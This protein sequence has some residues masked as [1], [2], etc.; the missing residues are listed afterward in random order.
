M[1]YTKLVLPILMCFSTH[2]TFAMQY[3]SSALHTASDMKE[4]LFTPEAK[5]VLVT[6][7]I[8]GGCHG[9]FKLCNRVLNNYR[10]YKNEKVSY[11]KKNEGGIVA[12]QEPV[13]VPLTRNDLGTITKDV[14]RNMG[15]K[16]VSVGM[17]RLILEQ[18]GS[19]PQVSSLKYL[20]VTLVGISA[21]SWAKSF[22]ENYYAPINYKFHGTF[23][24]MNQWIPY[25]LLGV[26]LW[27]AV[28]RY[29]MAQS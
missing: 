21:L 10:D 27:T 13:F 9:L 29:R 17:A 12:D 6:A 3:A 23:F 28:Q 24:R 1:N 25:G 11:D 4:L 20:V 26:S 2:V 14:L 18:H 19:W 22:D 7:G 5:T 16:G 8:I 15:T